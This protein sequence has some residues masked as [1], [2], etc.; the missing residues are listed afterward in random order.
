MPG[1]SAE[2][3]AM[4]RVPGDKLDTGVDV[5]IVANKT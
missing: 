3:N 2:G 1:V 4:G 5:V